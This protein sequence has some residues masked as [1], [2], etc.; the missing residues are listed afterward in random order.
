[1]NPLVTLLLRSIAGKLFQKAPEGSALNLMGTKMEKYDP[2]SGIYGLLQN[3]PV[4]GEKIQGFKSAVAPMIGEKIQGFKSAVAP[5]PYGTSQKQY[6]E[7]QGIVDSSSGLGSFGDLISGIYGE[8]GVM[9]GYNPVSAF[10]RGPVGAIENRISSI[11]NRTAPMTDFA[12]NQIWSLYDARDE[13]VG[14]QGINAVTR[15]GTYGYDD[16]MITNPPPAPP[17]GGDSG[18]GDSGGGWSGGSSDNWGGGF[19]SSQATL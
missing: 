2:I 12:R 10:G 17:S 4:I 16:V 11:M 19:D 9:Q 13:L 6:N 3:A 1:M 18:N 5:M 15:P 8:G 7:Y 14:G